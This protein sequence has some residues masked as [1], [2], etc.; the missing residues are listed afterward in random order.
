MVEKKSSAEFAD[1]PLILKVANVPCN[2]CTACCK[3]Q[4][5]ILYPQVDDVASYETE[6]S[7]FQDK[8]LHVLK[9]KPNGS[10]VYLGEKGCTIHYRAPAVCRAFDC[11]LWYL[12]FKNMSDKQKKT[13]RKNGF[14]FQDT[15]LEA[16]KSRLV[17]LKAK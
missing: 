16:G 2:G 3:V 11:R 9:Q 14:Q 13:M 8:T 6:E 15:V 1:A 12:H 4:R 7:I 5:V 10:C 17:T